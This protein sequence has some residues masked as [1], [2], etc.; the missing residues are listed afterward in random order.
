MVLQLLATIALSW[1]SYW[2]ATAFYRLF[3]HPLSKYPGPTVAIISNS[4]YEWYWNYYHNGQMIFEL[5]SLHKLHGPVV[6][7]GPNDL[8]V[9]D[10]EVYLQI[11]HVGSGFTKEPN[12]YKNISLP[13]T[14]IGET[15]PKKHRIRRKI[16]TPALSNTRV[17]ELASTVLH[18]VEQ[19]LARFESFADSAEIISFTGACHAL[20]L[21]VITQ[22]VFG[23]SSACVAEPGFRNEF[24]DHLDAAFAIGWIATAFPSLTAIALWMSPQF[25]L[26]PNPLLELKRRC[27][28]ITKKHLATYSRKAGHNTTSVLEHRGGRSSI[29]DLLLDPNSIKDYVVPNMEELNNEIV[30]LLAAGNDTTSNAMI[31][32]AYHIGND[33]KIQYRLSRELR[34]EFPKFEEGILYDQAKSLPYLAAV[35]KEVLRLGS[36]LPGRLPRLVPRFGFQLYGHKLPSGTS[37]HLSAYLLNRHPDIWYRAE[38]FLPERWLSADSQNLEKYVATFTRGT[39]QCL[40]KDLAW[41][42]LVTFF[43]NLFRRYNVQLINPTIAWS[44]LILVKYKDQL[45]GTVQRKKC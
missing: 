27:S 17:S 37:I 33:P 6:R 11:T 45:R 13:G 10:P 24:M 42:E 28:S 4:W 18:R 43:A 44:D 41:C 12:F 30:M 34:D 15:D 3:L 31:F 1:A 40:G 14:S 9:N 2:I 8:S 23:K 38:D 21:D 5:E 22:I 32:G 16:L 20:T 19:L 29:I 7:I 26:I 36:P 25:D 35:I 39:R